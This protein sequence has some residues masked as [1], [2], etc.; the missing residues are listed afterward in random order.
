MADSIFGLE[1]RNALILGGGQGMG[2][3]TAMMLAHAGANVALVDMELDRAERV[4]KRVEA[5]GRKSMALRVDA[6]N[7]TE[8]PQVI[9]RA[10][11]EMGGIDAM[12]TIIGMAGWAPLVDMSLETWDLDH[13]RNLRYFFIAARTVA[14]G[15]IARGKGAIVCIASVDGLRGAPFHASYGAAKAGLVNLVRTMTSEGASSG[16]RVNAIAPGSIITPRIPL[17]PPEEELKHNAAVPMKRRGSTDEIGKAALFLLSDLASYVTGQ[18]IA[19]DGGY[20]SES[21]FDY[22]KALG[23][24]GGGGTLGVK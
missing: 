24:A 8:L 2:E 13:R 9:E 21:A 11:R 3:S 4:R 16:I 20:I 6:L 7:D 5:L 19:V 14:R 10:D 18:T 1:G 17:R 23:Q 22:A 12:A 15:M